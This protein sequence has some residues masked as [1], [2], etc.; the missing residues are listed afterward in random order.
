MMFEKP[1]IFCHSEISV[2]YTVHDVKW[3][4]F[5][6][7]FL[8]VGQQANGEG[9]IE[10]FEMNNGQFNS[11]KFI[12]T[13]YGIKCCTFG[14][15]CSVDKVLATGNMTGSLEFWDFN[16]PELP[17]NSYNGHR[18]AINC[19][20]GVGGLNIG[21]GAPEIV[22]GSRDGK[23]FLKNIRSKRYNCYLSKKNNRVCYGLGSEKKR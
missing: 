1:Q 13:K 2:N 14:A 8:S 4:P 5:V 18:K 9:I 3:V 11:A 16:K 21:Y 19:I 17:V 22:T 10:I 12:R 20:D 6:P 15:S 7:K 23:H